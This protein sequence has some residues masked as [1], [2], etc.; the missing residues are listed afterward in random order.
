MDDAADLSTQMGYD[1]DAAVA[2][3]EVG[4]GIDSIDIK[5]LTAEV[6]ASITSGAAICEI[7][8]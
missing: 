1:F 6:G 5:D 4:V 8:D 2:Q 3:G 7:K